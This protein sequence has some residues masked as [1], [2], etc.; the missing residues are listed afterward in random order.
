MFIEDLKDFCV[1]KGLNPDWEEK[2]VSTIILDTQGKY[3]GVNTGKEGEQNL[4]TLS[5]TVRTS[6]NMPIPM[7]D[8]GEYVFGFENDNTAKKKTR[9]LDRH[10][11]FK[12]KCSTVPKVFGVA[13]ID[14]FYKNNKDVEQCIEEV[15][16]CHKNDRTKVSK[17]LFSFSI[18]DSEGNVEPVLKNDAV[19]RAILEMIQET[20]GELQRSVCGSGQQLFSCKHDYSS[21][22]GN[23]TFA[24]SSAESQNDMNK[25]IRAMS[26]LLKT[27][28]HKIN[29]P[30]HFGGTYVVDSTIL[31]YDTSPVKDNFLD[32]LFNSIVENTFETED[33]KKILDG[34]ERTITDGETPDNICLTHISQPKGATILREHKRIK[35]S[36]LI[37]NA[38]KAI[39]CFNNKSFKKVCYDSFS[40]LTFTSSDGKNLVDAYL[41]GDEINRKLFKKVIRKTASLFKQEKNVK[42]GEF[43]TWCLDNINKT[44]SGDMVNT[45]QYKLGQMLACVEKVRFKTRGGGKH[46]L[47]RKLSGKFFSAAPQKGY[48]ELVK[49]KNIY[50]DKVNAYHSGV[51]KKISGSLDAAVVL[52]ANKWNDYEQA[53]FLLGYENVMN[54]PFKENSSQ[55]LT[56]GDH[57]DRLGEET[58]DDEDM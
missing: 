37:D 24:A 58:E 3:C 49:S 29:L 48:L 57:S 56:D 38:N 41:F 4:P 44:G 52:E 36:E 45:E 46:T 43:L 10:K 9:A 11:L 47:F 26:Y 55:G 35:R 40:D 17:M 2:M 16:S 54:E 32:N 22:Y 21:Y 6:Q 1:N 23:N 18:K 7:Y 25:A 39:S 27:K 14:A 53:M 33:L 13:A 31:L 51:Y 19:L 50:C 42:T 34:K 15:L 5:F 30:F 20:V 28:E 12:E 8:Y